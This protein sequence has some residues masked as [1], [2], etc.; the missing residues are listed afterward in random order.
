[1]VTL[2]VENENKLYENLKEGFT[3]T[4]EWNK[5]RCQ[6]SNQ[7]ATNNLNYLIDPTFH[8]VNRL[9][10]LAYENEGDF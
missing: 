4:T 2:S 5:Y 6:I 7:T 9:F 10:V 1:M 3:M 8:N